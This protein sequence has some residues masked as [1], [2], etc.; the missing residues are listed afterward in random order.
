MNLQEAYNR[1]SF[2]I[3]KKTG[4]WYSPEELDDVADSGQMSL[5]ADLQP[6]Y[7]TSER[8]KDALAPFKRKWD[9]TPADTISGIIP[10]PSNLYF[11]N[12]LDVRI[13]YAISGTTR[14]VSLELPNE[15][16]MSGRLNSQIDPVTI[17]SPI[18]EIE[19]K[20]Y[21]RVYPTGSGYNGTVTFLRRPVKPNFVYSTISGRV[22]VYDD[23]AS[24]QLEWGE[25]W[26]NALLL[27][28]LNSIGIN[29]DDQELQQFSEMKS[30]QNFQNINR[31]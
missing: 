28:S 20:Q 12:L 8:I 13:T 25:N 26:I 23:A 22:I 31:T 18:G 29:L 24:T 14:Y 7:A 11:L 9:F 4:A 15:D 30:G 27:K 5:Y 21:I 17:T 3:N 10:I 6:I 2:W 1:L 19:S 16:E